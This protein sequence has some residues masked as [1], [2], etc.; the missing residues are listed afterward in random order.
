MGRSLRIIIPGMAYHV[1]SR[2]N[3]R[4]DI[5]RDKKD[6]IK[7]LLFLKDAIKIYD[8]RLYAYTLMSNHYHLLIKIEHS[9]ISSIMQYINTRY[10]VFFNWKYK[11]SGHL[12]HN[13]YKSVIVEH[14][15]ELQSCMRYIHLNPLRAK[16]AEDLEKYPWTSHRQYRGQ[17]DKGVAEPEHLLRL[18][19]NERHEA[20]A[21]Y[22]K[23][24]GEGGMKDKECGTMYSFGKHAI[25]S[26]DFVRKI[27]LMFKEKDLSRDI[28][29]RKELKKIYR[30]DIIIK[31]VCD[32]YG[33][34]GEELKKKGGWNNKKP[35]AYYLLSR[36]AGLKN[37]QIA[38]IFGGLHPSLIGR[39]V[40]EIAGTLEQNGKVKREL[41]LIRRK[42]TG[43][44]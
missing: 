32:Y 30:Q 22:E 7:F 4:K 26:E 38:E 29:N 19:S 16:M 37:T 21:K 40:N 31:A 25:G 35:A 14:G 20:I 18:F 8:F 3:E 1:M 43:E 36:D 13:K 5:Y 41:G 2:G 6:R 44:K 28:N 17:D 34:T 12:F 10:A 33:M 27:K 24:M 23:Y 11:R 42:Y 9:N 15:P 39:K